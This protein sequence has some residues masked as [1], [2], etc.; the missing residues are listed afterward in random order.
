MD[1]QTNWHKSCAE[2]QTIINSMKSATREHSPFFLTF[3]HHSNYPLPNISP[4]ALSYNEEGTVAAKLNLAKRT[5]R[6]IETLTEDAFQKYKQQF[7]SHHP[8]TTPYLLA[9]QIRAVNLSHLSYLSSHFYSSFVSFEL[10]NP[11]S[12]GKYILFLL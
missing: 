6:T 7:L 4:R 3:F 2:L 5:A 8:Q 10:F 9:K 12:P 11:E 1:E